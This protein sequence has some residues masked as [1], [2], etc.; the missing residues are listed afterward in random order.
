MAHYSIGE[1]ANMAGISIRT[2]RYY[3]KIGLL[4]PS[5][6]TRSRYR[7]YGEEE[8]LRL[9]QILFYKEL[10]F[11]LHEIKSILDNSDF[12]V[13]EAL[14]SHKVALRKRQRRIEQLFVTIDK[15]IKNL[16]EK[17]MLTHEELYE[18][19]P[20]Q[21]AEAWRN[22]SIK[23]WGE[24]A[25]KLSETSLKNMSREEFNKL[26]SDFS[27]NVKRLASMLGENPESSAVQAAVAL[28]YEHILKFWG[29][30]PKA[31]AYKGL[32]Q[33]YV[34]DER[35][36]I[37]DGNPNTAFARFLSQAMNYFA[38]THLK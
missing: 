19:L 38:D 28:H 33:L 27:D 7:R 24:H 15:T 9:Q 18:G 4:K 6:R 14:E 11:T 29:R 22:E 12:D 25:I 17:T 10:D 31:E 3:D 13:I 32:G 1:L 35:Y 36:T 26:K 2:L 37:V 34:N 20:K 5:V 16:K 21:K 30:K 8:L 23:K